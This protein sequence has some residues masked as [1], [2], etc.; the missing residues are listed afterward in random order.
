MVLAQ[1][2]EAA[3]PPQCSNH[4]PGLAG[5]TGRRL[6]SATLQQWQ[7]E[8]LPLAAQV[9][10]TPS[11]P[12]L[13]LGRVV[14]APHGLPVQHAS[15]G[16]NKIPGA[17]DDRSYLHLPSESR[18]AVARLWHW[19]SAN[20]DLHRP[21]NPDRS[22]AIGAMERFHHHEPFSSVDL[23]FP[24]CTVCGGFTASPSTRNLEPHQ[25]RPQ[26]LFA[27]LGRFHISG[28]H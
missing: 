14:L 17:F 22:T 4:G 28:V 25:Q 12:N 26:K 24:H 16:I 19:H 6:P 2:A 10:R 27:Y 15:L 18:K 1:V 5:S 13:R 11:H 3:L 9:K 7:F 8:L 23:F 21:S 20:P